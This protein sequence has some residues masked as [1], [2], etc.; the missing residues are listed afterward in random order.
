V[1]YSFRSGGPHTLGERALR[2]KRLIA[3]RT[4]VLVPGA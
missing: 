4:Q 1:I 2:A 3:E